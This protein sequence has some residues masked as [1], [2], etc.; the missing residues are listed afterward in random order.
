MV[1]WHYLLNGHE[2][3]QALGD[4]GGQ[5]RL[6][7]CSSWGSQR[8]GYARLSEQPK[9]H[10]MLLSK[11]VSIFYVVIGKAISHRTE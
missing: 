2:F 5:G 9:R 3:G 4:G 7:C 11:A 1:E 6:A 10:G 8:V